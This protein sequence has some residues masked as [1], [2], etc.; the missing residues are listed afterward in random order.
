MISSTVIAERLVKVADAAVA[1]AS[2]RHKSPLAGDVTRLSTMFTSER[3]SRE[4]TYMRDPALRRAYLGFFVPHNV[5]RIALL[6]QRAHQEG[7]LPDREAPRVVDVGAG[8]LTG[9]LACWAVYGRLGPSWAIDLSKAALEDGRELLAA[10]GADVSMLTLWDKSLNA[11]PGTWLPVGDVDVIVAANVLNELS[12]PRLPDLRLRVVDA[13]VKALL[14]GGRM[15]VVEPSMRVEARSL[16]TVRDEVVD[17]GVASVLSPC[18]GAERCP[19][20]LTRGDWCH[21][22]V[23]W[24][25]HP[26]SFRELEK[27][28]KLRKDLLSSTHLLLARPDEVAPTTGLRLVGGVMRAGERDMRYA[29]G[30]ELIT[31]T[32]APRLAPS[33]ALPLRGA[34]VADQPAQVAPTT[35]TTTTTAQPLRPP[36]PPLAP[37]RAPRAKPSRSAGEAGGPPGPRSQR[38]QGRRGPGK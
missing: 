21:G 23:M 12:D 19:L 24:G 6:L 32:G 2:R 34:L 13:C 3:G 9:L 27:A 31:L 17:G 26:E 4:R 30:R 37:T 8:P 36:L 11:E 38:P 35:T 15:L 25:T 28:V 18:R 16:M 10:V 1:L 7:H 22:E 29:C 5:A 20:L 14:P 33:L